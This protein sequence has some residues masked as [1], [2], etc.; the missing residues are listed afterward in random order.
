MV[1]MSRYKAV[2]TNS[3]SNSYE[4]Y[5]YGVLDTES[6]E[7]VPGV[8]GYRHHMDYYIEHLERGERPTTIIVDGKRVRHWVQR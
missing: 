3:P 7:M 6:G 5:L 4:E 1:A 2:I 8:G